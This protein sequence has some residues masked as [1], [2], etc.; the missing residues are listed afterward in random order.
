MAIVLMIAGLLLVAVLQGRSMLQSMQVKNTMAIAADLSSATRSF[1]E[2]YHYLPGDLPV[3]AAPN[4]EIT[5]LTGTCSVGGNGD[6][7]IKVAQASGPAT[8]TESACAVI[9]LLHAGLIRAGGGYVRSH[10]GAV[11]IVGNSI[12]AGSVTAAGTNPVPTTIIN[13]I[14]FDDL[15]CDVAL[16]IDLK[17]DDGNLATGRARASVATCTAGTGGTIVPSFAVPL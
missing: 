9:H 14:E 1:R 11:R 10:Y 5:D 7:V 13:L 17:L 15:P 16:E 6:G 12:A 2:R 4:A 8:L 3:S